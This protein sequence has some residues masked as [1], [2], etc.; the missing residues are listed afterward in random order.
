GARLADRLGSDDADGLTD[1]DLVAASEVASVALRA[2]TTTGL[3]REHR[4]DDDL[5]DARFFNLEDELFVELRVER[6]DD[7]AG[8]RV[9]DVFQR[10]AAEDAVAEGLDDFAGV[11]EL[12]HADTV[13]GA[14]VE[15]G[16]DRVLR[17]VD[18]ST[19]E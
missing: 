10:H 19:R 5:F 6:N 17:D 12:R 15:L 8:E 7:F 14:A 13:E 3:A 4:A 2:D 18:E 9:D 11:F 16:D 1:V